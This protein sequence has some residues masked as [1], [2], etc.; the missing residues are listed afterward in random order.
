M[1]RRFKDRIEAGRLLGEALQ[2]HAGRR[3]VI[4]L[5]LPRGGVPVAAEVARRLGVDLDVCLVRKLG[6]PGRGELAMGALA[7][8]GAR[9][10]NP[11]V[12]RSH[13]VS[14]HALE[15]A[16]ARESGELLRREQRYRA[17]RPP[18]DV[19]GRTVLL[20][21][22]GIA[23]GATLRAA[24]LALRPMGPAALVIAVP[25]APPS[26]LRELARDADGAVCLRP[27]ENLLAVGCWYDDF[28][29]TTDEEVQAWL[30]PVSK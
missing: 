4:V 1:G 16:T 12:I 10:L 11:E 9:V 15:A 29:Q 22:D 28:R 25:V 6:T 24:L 18:L 17:G 27:V 21:D 7:S 5:G 19:K 20:V 2:A 23:T 8:G 3:E 13:G 14:P 26:T 30:G